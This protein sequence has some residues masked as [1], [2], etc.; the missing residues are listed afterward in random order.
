LI[1]K[2]AHKV[3]KQSSLSHNYNTFSNLRARCKAQNKIDYNIF[4]RKTQNSITRNPK[5]FWQYVNNKRSIHSLPNSMYYNSNNISG[6]TDITNCFAQYFSSV[7]NIP[8]ILQT[9]SYSNNTNFHSVDLN[10][11][12]LTFSDVYNALNEITYKTCPGPDNPDKIANIFFIQCKF[13]LSSPLLILFNQSLSIGVIPDKWK[14]SYISSV[15]KSGDINYV[16]NYRPVSIISIIPKIFEGIIYK[17]ISPL[18]KYF[19]IDEQHG[20][21]SGRSTACNLLILQN[22]ILNAFKL[23]CQVGI[24]FTDFAKAFD[25]IDHSILAKN[26]FQFGIWSP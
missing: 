6:G 10:S 12:T 13:V 2:I 26:L 17:K 22:Y 4:I 3:Y 20:F 19:I 21:M 1:K 23:N 25:M 7:L 24:I 16:I 9:I 8:S 5:R 11:Y 18:F 14:I 15:F